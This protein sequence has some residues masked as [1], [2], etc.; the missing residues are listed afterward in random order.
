MKEKREGRGWVAPGSCGGTGNQAGRC[1]GQGQS[2]EQA[3]G[4]SWWRHSGFDSGCGCGCLSEP[5]SP[6]STFCLIGRTQESLA[7]RET[8][9]ESFYGGRWGLLKGGSPNPRR[10]FRGAGGLPAG[11]AAVSVLHGTKS[12]LVPASPTLCFPPPTFSL[13]G[14]MSFILLANSYSFLKIRSGVV[15]LGSI[16]L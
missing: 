9:R 6:A 14:E 16:S 4:V 15:F 5:G 12:Q 3:A 1:Y 8:G 11:Q 10:V 7:E 13:S 2:P